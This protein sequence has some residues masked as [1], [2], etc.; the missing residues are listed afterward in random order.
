[1]DRHR[2]DAGIDGGGDVS[3]GGGCGGAGVRDLAGVQG[4]GELS[5][6]GAVRISAAERDGSADAGGGVSCERMVG[7]AAW[8][9]DVVCV[10][11]VGVGER[12]CVRGEDGGAVSR[13]W[14]A[15]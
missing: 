10:L 6:G 3:G 15:W 7:D 14:G 5:S 11:W 13:A 9:A 2:E 1:M 4:V 8:S 12:G